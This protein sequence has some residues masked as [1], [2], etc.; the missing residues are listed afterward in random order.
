MRRLAAALVVVALF[1]LTACSTLPVAS[2]SAPAGSFGP[3]ASGGAIG[4]VTPVTIDTTLLAVLPREV[5]SIPV[6]ESPE[7]EA[8]AQADAVLPTIA[9]AAVAA[10]AVD[11]ATSDLV[12]VLVVRLR[13]GVLTADRY[14]DWRDSYDEGACLGVSRVVGHAEVNIGVHKVFIGTCANG[15]RT[16]H[17]WLEDK[18]ILISASST[19]TR[20]F[21]VLLFGTLRT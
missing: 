8:D 5:S 21:G 16:Y 18:A 19:G 1:A 7:G 9:T 10:V 17:T 11:A 6:I 20:E 4:S 15:L 3:P 2:S 12:Y 13:P 14:R